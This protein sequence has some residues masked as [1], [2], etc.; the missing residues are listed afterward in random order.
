ML[1]REM[2][3]AERAEW[4]RRELERHNVLY[5]VQEAPEI[6]DSEWDKL[7]RELV[8]L[9][10][11]NP[12]L[13]TAD[14]PTQRVG[15]APVS[16]FDSYRHGVPMLSLDNA[17]GEEEVRAFDERIRRYLSKQSPETAP[18]VVDYEVELKFDGLS[19]S[20]TYIDGVLAVA[21]TRGD[22]TT[23]EDV[24]PNARTVSGVPL[25]LQEPVQGT[26]EVR[27]EVVMY[28]EVFANLNQERTEKGLQIF[29][30]PRNAA[31]GG[32]RQLDSRLTAQRKLS[33]MSYGL[34]LSN[35]QTPLPETQIGRMEWLRTLGFRVW[36][37]VK[38]CRGA[39]ELVAQVQKVQELRNSLPFQIDGVVVKVNELALQEELGFTARGPRWAVAVKFPAE[40]AFTKLNAIS[41]NVGRTGAVT[42]FAEL[43][44]VYVGGATVALATLHNYYELERKDVRAGDTVIVQRA[45]DVI[46]EVV[47]PVLEK[48]PPDAVPHVPP[49]ECPNCGAALVREEGMTVLRCPNIKGCPAQVQRKLEHFASRGAMDI[50][51]LGEKQIARFVDL[52][53]LH[54]LPSIY[55]LHKRKDDMLALERMGELSVNNLFA[56]IEAS[57]ERTMDRFLYA[58]GIRFVGDRTAGDLAREFGSV[59]AFRRAT[60]DDLEAIPDIGPRTAEIVSEWL[61]EA[62]NQA[63]IQGLL[64]AGVRPVEAA[65]PT[66]D[67]FAGQTFVFTGKLERFSR[68]N[69][70]ALVMAQGGKAAGSVS[71]NTTF[72]VAGP[73]AGSKLDKATQLGVTVLTEEEFL[74]LVPPGTFGE[75]PS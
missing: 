69:A 56:A 53:W 43:E 57:K 48:R 14:S 67:L 65:K 11:A 54:D 15:V 32:M 72:V 59:E 5:Y 9:E 13:R 7:F 74:A 50:D 64:D 20:L 21:A 6:S 34:G 2:T 10:E 44:P 42:P 60:Y 47:G 68:E 63:L 61:S 4:L 71:K 38:L 45:G 35:V 29:A 1:L 62:E 3:S 25:R 12:E 17:F 31:A 58:L 37:E 49:T 70:E 73:G 33:F 46:P 41:C 8:D 39:D 51:G 40:Q 75:N 36:T 16:K 24:T 26:I 23:G 66:G 27:G 30:N 18:T 22:G 55:H 52:G 19:M 28:K